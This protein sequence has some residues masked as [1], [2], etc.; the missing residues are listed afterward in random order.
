MHTSCFSQETYSV[1]TR[2]SVKIYN[3][4]V[5]LWGI[6]V[7]KPRFIRS[8]FPLQAP[9]IYL[10]VVNEEKCHYWMLFPQSLG[11]P[12]HWLID[13]SF[14]IRAHQLLNRPILA[15]CFAILPSWN[16]VSGRWKRLTHCYHQ[17]IDACMMV[18]VYCSFS[19]SIDAWKIGVPLIHFLFS[20]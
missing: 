3:L 2:R 6:R 14:K 20:P 18:K 13:L 16:E 19:E 17:Y 11:F 12:L 9:V 5:L 8:E 1:K 10:L 7:V 15:P 4:S